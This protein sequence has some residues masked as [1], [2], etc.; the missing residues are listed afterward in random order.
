[1]QWVRSTAFYI[2]RLANL[3]KEASS[4]EISV[5]WLRLYGLFNEV[6]D[7]FADKLKNLEGFFAGTEIPPQVQSDLNALKPPLAAIDKVMGRLS[8]DELLYLKYRR[9]TEAHVWQDAYRLG[10]TKSQKN[11][12]E[13]RRVF[14]SD[15]Q[16]DELNERIRQ[17]LLKFNVNEDAIA[18]DFAR[19]LHPGMTDVVEA[20]TRYCDS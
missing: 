20:C 2:E 18:V 1:M 7:D 3:G 8:A 17:M 5:F 13:K 10:L 11:L 19:R 15:W 4:A 9:D 6:R 12:S 16:I 14:G